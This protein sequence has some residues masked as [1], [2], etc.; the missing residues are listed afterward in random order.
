MLL[1]DVAAVLDDGARALRDRVLARPLMW[2]GGLSALW[3][4]LGLVEVQEV[5]VLTT[6]EFA[7]AADH[8]ASFSTSEGSIGPYLR[9]LPEEAG[10]TIRGHVRH[11]YLAG[12]EDGPRLFTAILRVARGR[13]VQRTS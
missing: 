11:A 7:D 10:S 5:P 4:E 12:K 3:R 8:W 13:V 2:T 6:F 9:N 1:L